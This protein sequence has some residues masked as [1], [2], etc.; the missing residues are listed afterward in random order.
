MFASVL[1]ELKIKKIDQT[2]TYII[3]DKLKNQV[4]IGKRV[5][6]PFGGQKL[7][8]FVID[9][10]NNKSD[11]KLKEIIEVI[12]EYPVLNEEMLELGRYISKKTICN[13]I[14]CYQTMLPSALKAKNG[15]VVNKKYNTYLKIKNE[16]YEPK[17]E[18][19]K[20]L[21][22]II[23]E[24]NFIIK[25]EANKI[26]SSAVN[27]L[28]KN[29]VLE[30]IKEE[31]YRLKNNVLKEEKTIKLNDEQKQVITNV[32]NSNGFKPYL[33]FGVTGSGKT[34]VYMHLIEDVIKEGKEAIVLVPEISLTPQ[35][36]NVF[37]KR[38]G[39]NLAILHSGLSNGEKYD[40]WR[41]IE[42]KEVKIAVGARSAIFA[43]F[44]NLG[45]IIIDEEHSSTYKQENNP[46]Y[47]AI[48]LALFRGKKH[49]IKV[50]LGSAT[51]SLESYT[52]AITGSYELLVLKNRIN[53]KLPLVH[54]VDMKNEIKK[55]NAIL[56]EILKNK[57]KE[58]IDKD[59]QVIILLNRRGY[60]TVTTC[61]SCG[62]V[63]K[64][65]AC[66]IPLT[67]HKSSNLM[68]CHYCGHGE[69]VLLECPV[70]HSKVIN[71]FGIGTEKLEQYLIDTFEN[72]KVVRMDNDT[73]STKGSHENIIESFRKKQYNI[74]VGTQMISK[75]LDFPDVTLV[76]VINADSS[77]NIPDFRSAERTFELINQ[78]SGRSGRALLDGEVVIQGF[79][80]DHYSI[81][82]SSN[83]DYEG[84]YKEEMNIRKLLKYSPY[85][86]LTKILIR[87]N[88]YDEALKEANKISNYLRSKK[89]D[90]YIL[91]PAP[92]SI[93]KINNI[94]NIQIILKYKKSD[95]LMK[96][97][98]YINDLYRTKKVS[99]D[100]DINPYII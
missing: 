52:R 22:N 75:G 6:V 94:Y 90:V 13:L 67:Y 17:N 7:E 59:E 95:L 33:L 99:V 15:F 51:P 74:L 14:N 77:L 65:N 96:E 71:F 57:I 28:L 69:R 73:T 62:Y 81:V 53:N 86:N 55:G 31:E 87:Y 91:G 46:K 23:I 9:I 44:T 64:C 18:I 63:H 27:T 35:L 11:Y 54:L 50:I 98:I 78:V 1:V 76:G 5:T 2:F 8:G 41:K 10:N 32:N 68:R 40:E 37:K 12:D 70:C 88:D 92:S 16:T 42:R 19:Q 4:E 26:S 89:L 20:Y 38:F 56:S 43:P 100:I 80:I 84:F 60:N 85:Y 21:I 93:T 45:I 83:N 48:D 97:L 49:N 25:S 24:N 79:N 82:K 29:N 34:E 47:N 30:E 61:K 58:R 66:D 72:A 36:I 3:P 39:D